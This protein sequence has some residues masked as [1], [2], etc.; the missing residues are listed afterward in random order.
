MSQLIVTVNVF[1]IVGTSGENVYPAEVENVL[2]SCPGVAEVAVIGVPDARLGKAIVVVAR[3]DASNEA[4]LR[5]ARLVTG[6]HE[7]VAMSRHIRANIAGREGSP[8]RSAPAI[9]SRTATL[10]GI[11]RAEPGRRTTASVSITSCCPRK[12][13][14]CSRVARSRRWG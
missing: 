4:A 7:I 3:G 11:I 13:A 5:M 2:M 1:V 8:M 10:S 6:R 12:R 14:T 9:P